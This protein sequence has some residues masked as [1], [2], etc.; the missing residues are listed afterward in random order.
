MSATD[1]Q[2]SGLVCY[3]QA[4]QAQ[5]Q[6]ATA[7]IFVIENRVKP[8][9]IAKLEGDTRDPTGTI[10][11]P[12]FILSYE[13]GK[14]VGDGDVFEYSKLRT[15]SPFAFNKGEKGNRCKELAEVFKDQ[16]KELDEYISMRREMQSGST[17]DDIENSCANER[18]SSPT[19]KEIVTQHLGEWDGKL[20]QV[21]L[22]LKTGVAN[23]F[24]DRRWIENDKWNELSKISWKGELKRLECGAM[25]EA[26]LYVDPYLVLDEDQS[27]RFKEIFVEIDTKSRDV[28]IDELRA[29]LTNNMQSI[30]MMTQEELDAII[31]S[32]ACDHNGRV[33]FDEFLVNM[34]NR[35]STETWERL[36]PRKVARFEQLFKEF[37]TGDADCFCVGPLFKEIDNHQSHDISIDE[38]RAVVTRNKQRLG[39]HQEEYTSMLFASRD[40]DQNRRVSLEEFLI[41][42]AKTESGRVKHPIIEIKIDCDEE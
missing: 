1:D 16:I 15:V 26:G 6:G 22:E 18:S 17:H 28:G 25:W 37:S 24:R 12:V 21:E 36:D 5:E 2:A 11:I 8:R 4:R 13:D 32:A 20:K 10:E 3:E 19:I 33:N 30:G 34:A 29:A 39:I 38:L 42:M 31:A 40:R 14:R 41:L 9:D 7:V 27:A 35:E 23:K